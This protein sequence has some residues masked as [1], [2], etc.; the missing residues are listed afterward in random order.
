MSQL[1]IKGRARLPEQTSYSGADIIAHAVIPLLQDPTSV[2]GKNRS[3]LLNT[4]QTI[5]IT[6]ARSLSPVRVLGRG[7]PI[8][9]TRGGRTV[10]GTM[11]FASLDRDAFHD[12]YRASL[13]E[14]HLDSKSYLFVDQLPPF[15]I[16]ITA[17]N[18]MGGIS[19]QVIS[20]ITLANYGQTYSIDDVYTEITYTYV[21]KSATPLTPD[22]DIIGAMNY[23][24]YKSPLDLIQEYWG[25]RYG[26]AQ[27]IFPSL[28]DI[29]GDTAEGLWGAVVDPNRRVVPKGMEKFTT[30]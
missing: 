4:L 10:A 3:I 27:D 19:R 21:A 5:S 8:S 30:Q 17:S 7:F 13:A 25:R 6:S 18:E 15:N 29:I 12:I 14:S 22:A 16:V 28:G 23:P 26:S 20:D 11:V 9:Y 2:P 24:F 1:P